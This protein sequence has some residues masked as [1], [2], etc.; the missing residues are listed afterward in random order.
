MFWHSRKHEATNSSADMIHCTA[1]SKLPRSD[2]QRTAHPRCRGQ[3]LQSIKAVDPRLS[4]DDVTQLRT[5]GVEPE[6]Y[7]EVKAI[8]P[9]LSIDDITRLRTHGSSPAT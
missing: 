3:I 7:Q 8:D 2:D 1:I 4:I 5:H 9:E 6:Y